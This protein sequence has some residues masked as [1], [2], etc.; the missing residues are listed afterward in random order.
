MS[1]E[2]YILPVNQRA[3]EIINV[4]ADGTQYKSKADH[5]KYG[6]PFIWVNQN[7][8]VDLVNKLK[9]KTES[10]KKSV[11]ALVQKSQSVKVF[12]NVE[13]DFKPDSTELA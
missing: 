12:M 5:E 13:L 7:Q 3:V 11:V 2:H 6:E 9:P 4:L 1:V 8:L 10:G